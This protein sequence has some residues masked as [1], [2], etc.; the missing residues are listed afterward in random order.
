MY[1]SL[2]NQKRSKTLFPSVLEEYQ[3][4][5]RNDDEDE[6]DQAREKLLVLDDDDSKLSRRDALMKDDDADDDKGGE[7]KEEEYDDDD[8]D[9]FRAPP[10]LSHARPRR[11]LLRD[12]VNVIQ[13]TTV[14][15]QTRKAKRKKIWTDFSPA[16]ITSTFSGKDSSGKFPRAWRT[17]SSCYSRFGCRGFYSS[18]WIG[19]V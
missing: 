2:P 10:G 7:E 16:C 15:R 6:D 18:P 13:T 4:N 5:R 9:D 1:S 12:D 19:S 11:G 3:R 17:R 8:I 14:T